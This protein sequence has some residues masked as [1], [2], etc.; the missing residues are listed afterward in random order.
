MAAAVFRELLARH[1]I[2]RA[3][4]GYD[5]AAW[6]RISIGTMAQNRAC[7]AA[8]EEVLAAVAAP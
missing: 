4:K 3:L 2:V 1:I 5:L 6:I 7:L 8:L